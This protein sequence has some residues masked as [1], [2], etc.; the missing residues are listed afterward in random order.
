MGKS[1]PEDL[2]LERLGDLDFGRLGDL[3]L[4]RLGDL[5]L[6]CLGDLAALISI[7]D[8][9]IIGVGRIERLLAISKDL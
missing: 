1:V 8:V 6:E 7:F 2:D 3:D 5:D 9:D 4:G